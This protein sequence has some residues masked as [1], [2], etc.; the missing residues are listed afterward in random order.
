MKEELKI[1]THYESLDIAQS[2]R[3]HYLL[4]AAPDP[5]LPLDEA[6][7]KRSREMEPDAG[8][9]TPENHQQP[10]KDETAEEGEDFYYDPDGL[11][12]LTGK[13]SSG[14][15]ILLRQRVQTLPL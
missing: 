9:K 10:Q 1:K 4:H 3:V 6:C 8:E 2:R 11:M 7:R 12:V 15:R 5:L 14:K 13:I